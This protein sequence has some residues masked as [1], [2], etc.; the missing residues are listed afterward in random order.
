MP[1]RPIGVL[2]V[3]TPALDGGEW[4][5]SHPSS[6]TPRERNP[7]TQWITELKST[8]FKSPAIDVTFTETKQLIQKSLGKDSRGFTWEVEHNGGNKMTWEIIWQVTNVKYRTCEKEINF[9]NNWFQHNIHG[10]L[11]LPVAVDETQIQTETNSVHVT[12]QW[13]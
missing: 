2:E 11:T 8:N 6:F 7:G 10:L 13:C 4:S 9:L 12:E 1:W 5:A 3:Q